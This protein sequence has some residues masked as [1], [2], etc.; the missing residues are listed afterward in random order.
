MDFRNMVILFLFVLFLSSASL[1]GFFYF[2]IRTTPSPI[3]VPE[4]LLIQPKVKPT[5][6][7]ETVAE[8]PVQIEVPIF[9]LKA[10]QS[11]LSIENHWIEPESTITDRI[12]KSMESLI[13]GPFSRDLV[14]VIPPATTVQSVFWDEN[15]KRIYINFSEDLIK[16]HPGHAL[17]EWATIYA[18]VDTAVAQAPHLIDEVQI[19]VNGEAVK[20]VDML[21]DWS[22]PFKKDDMFVQYKV[23][24]S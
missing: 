7:P 18:I 17:A 6:K 8:E 24:G 13:K 20:D 21:W 1:A 2:Q 9:F 3:P 14:P 23:E 11:Q 22:L 10:D 16:D 4:K 12:R 5:E 15:G 19:L